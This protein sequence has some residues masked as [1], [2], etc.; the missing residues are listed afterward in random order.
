MK[1]MVYI[2]GPYTDPD[3]VENTKRAIEIGTFLMDTWLVT[4]YVPH[5]S[6][7]WHLV[8]PR[9]WEDWIALDLDVIDHCDAVLRLPGKSKGAELEVAHAVKL[10]LPVFHEPV[11]VLAWAQRQ[12][13]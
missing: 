13:A 6:M 7:F 3:P 9:P 5:L 8:T 11:D 10:M 4:P 2:A 1:P 12:A